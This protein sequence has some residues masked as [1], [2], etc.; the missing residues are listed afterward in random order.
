MTIFRAIAMCS[1]VACGKSDS[2]ATTGAASGSTPPGS[3]TTT[4][5]SA[6]PSG[7][8]EGKWTGTWTRQGGPAGGGELVLNVGATTTFKRANT[9][10]PPEE[11]P[12]I[13][14]VDGD[15]VTIEVATPEVTATYSGKRNGK[16]IVGELVTTC[17]LGTGHGVWKLAA[18]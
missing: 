1:L 11:T 10:C 14:K 17:K 4:T 5:G 3:A 18:L 16:E 15:N 7:A 9:L 2:K 6:K 13:V 12:A 8:L